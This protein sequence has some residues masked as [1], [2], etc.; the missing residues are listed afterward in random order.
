MIMLISKIGT[1]TQQRKR[2]GRVT[3]SSKRGGG[4]H[5]GSICLPYGKMQ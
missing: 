1:L 3:V 4:G 5:D 2:L